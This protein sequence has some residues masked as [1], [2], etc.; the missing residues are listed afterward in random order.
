MPGVG[1]GSKKKRKKSGLFRN[2]GGSGREVKNQTSILE[3]YFCTE[4]V[5]SF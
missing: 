1:K 3:K 4:H 5:E 2:Q